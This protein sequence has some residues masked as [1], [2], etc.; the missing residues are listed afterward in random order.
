[1]RM[2]PDY[3]PR[4]VHGDDKVRNTL[5]MRA[6]RRAYPAFTMVSWHGKG[7]DGTRP[8]EARNRILASLSADQTH[9]GNTRGSTPG[10]I[11]PSQPD[12]PQNRIKQPSL[13][14]GAL[15]RKFGGRGNYPRQHEHPG[16]S[17]HK[18]FIGREV[19]PSDRVTR[20]KANPLKP[21][22]KRRRLYY[23]LSDE[24]LDYDR[25]ERTPSGLCGDENEGDEA[26]QVKVEDVRITYWRVASVLT[27]SQAIEKPS[28]RSSRRRPIIPRTT[29]SEPI[30]AS[31]YSHIE[32]SSSR[33]V[34]EAR[35]AGV[36]QVVLPAGYRNLAQEQGPYIPRYRQALVYP[37]PN[38]AQPSV[39]YEPYFSHAY[40]QTRYWEV[41]SR[42][43]L[44]NQ[45]QPTIHPTESMTYLSHT[46]T[47]PT[48]S[49]TYPTF[50][51]TYPNSLS[52]HPNSPSTYFNS[53]PTHPSSSSTYPTSST[54]ATPSTTD[55]TPSTRYSTP[56]MLYN[57]PSLDYPNTSTT[58]LSHSTPY[59][60]DSAPHHYPPPNYPAPPS[61]THLLNPDATLLSHP[62]QDAQMTAWNP[63]STPDVRRRNPRPQPPSFYEP[64]TS[65]FLPFNGEI[66]TSFEDAQANWLIR[67]PK[68]SL[69]QR[70]SSASPMQ[71]HYLH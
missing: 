39:N 16:E 59:Q 30:D 24:D 14:V 9:N 15:T 4:T 55:H 7:L 31:E 63:P 44:P 3:L 48:S 11:N 58:Y 50:A 17:S 18:A 52:T 21:S 5:N 34:I 38:D 53:L 22:V 33:A 27:F 62:H 2:K 68:Q 8:H 13:P 65:D 46:P 25:D 64:E 54:Y 70:P 10:L 69:R 47:F 36:N 41:P 35:R 40:P 61:G 49:S 57:N 45:R 66:L 67:L 6:S 42:L 12:T 26:I 20:S 29:L 1:M 32:P 71:R 28:S 37:W 23:E 56:S 19:T 51:S 60:F 43:V